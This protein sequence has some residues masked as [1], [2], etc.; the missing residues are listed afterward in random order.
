MRSDHLL[1]AAEAALVAERSA[2]ELLEARLS[3]MA[4]DEEKADIVHA[5][6]MVGGRATVGPTAKRGRP[7]GS[8]AVSAQKRDTKNRLPAEAKDEKPVKFWLKK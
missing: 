2:R 3:A 6:P 5:E 4:D 8:G 7:V 1:N